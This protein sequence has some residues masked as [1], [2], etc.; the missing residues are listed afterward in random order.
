M[1][2]KT[3]FAIFGIAAALALVVLAPS[4]TS[5][6]SAKK[7]ETCTVG[8]SDTPCNHTGIDRDD[9]PAATKTCSNPGGGSP[10]CSGN[11]NEVG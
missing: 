10:N 8:G 5:E 9:S 7:T 3:T 11:V 6:V 4:L 2:T 1:N